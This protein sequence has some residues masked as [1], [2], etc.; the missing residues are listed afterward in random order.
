MTNHFESNINPFIIDIEDQEEYTYEE[1]IN[2][3]NLHGKYFKD[4]KQNHVNEDTLLQVVVDEWQE[5]LKTAGI[6]CT[7]YIIDENRLLVTLQQGW[8]GYEAREFLLDQSYVNSVEW[9]GVNYLNKD[10]KKN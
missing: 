7:I 10:N 9:D 5:L 3:D 6:D 2:I 8:R 4:Q 1:Y